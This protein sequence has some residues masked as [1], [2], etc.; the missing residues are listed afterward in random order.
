[1]KNGDWRVNVSPSTRSSY[2]RR[3]YQIIR[4]RAIAALGGMCVRCSYSDFRA[5]QIDHVH[6]G[7][8]RERQQKKGTSY[9]YHVLKNL[10][11]GRYQ[12]LCANCNVIK[13]LEDQ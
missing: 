12:V 9:F 8:H 2:R 6:G 11:S 4:H 1:M 7:G 13:R 10:K 5:L 3:W